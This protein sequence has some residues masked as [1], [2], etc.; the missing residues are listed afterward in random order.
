MII[1]PY[2]SG[3]QEANQA[4]VTKGGSDR[5]S[6][7]IDF[8]DGLISSATT[9]TSVSAI[10]LGSTGA[11]TTATVV[12]TASVSGTVARIDLQT[13]GVGGTAAALNGDRF[14]MVVTCV[15]FTGGPLSFPV[16]IYIEAPGYDVS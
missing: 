7:F 11:V 10:A 5:P 14:K 3:Q 1:F 16:F 12:G 4:L 13:C 9:I 2:L 8:A 15:P 6:V